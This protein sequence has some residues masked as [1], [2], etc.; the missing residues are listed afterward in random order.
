MK[1]ILL[2]SLAFAATS[3]FAAAKIEQ[4]T[5]NPQPGVT[6]TQTIETVTPPA[7]TSAEY[8][9]EQTQTTQTTVCYMS[10]SYKFFA[11]LFKLNIPKECQ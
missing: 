9:W 3:S 8:Y 4:N 1:K 6:V 11:K 2:T 7:T 5:Y 10:N